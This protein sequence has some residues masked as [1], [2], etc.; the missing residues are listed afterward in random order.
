MSSTGRILNIARNALAAQESA[1]NTTGHNIA[2]VNTPGYSR[3]RTLFIPS[4]P[5]ATPWGMMGAGVDIATIEQLRD[6]FIDTEIRSELQDFGK[7]EYKERIFSQIE[8]IYNEPSD[9]GL[10]AVLRE[11]WD[12]WSQLANDPQSSSSRERV[13]QTGV[14][15]TNKFHNLDSRLKNL[16]SE[17]NEE[18]KHNIKDLNI[19]LRQVADLNKQIVQNENN[20]NMANDYRDRRSVLLEEISKMAN[21]NVTE[22]EHGSVTLT[23]DGN[24]LVERDTVNML[25]TGEKSIGY[26]ALSSP[27]MANTGRTVSILSGKL[28]GIMEMRD[29]VVGRQQEQLNEI[30]SALIHDVNAIHQAG[31]GRDGLSGRNFFDSNSINIGNIALDSSILEDAG[32]IAASADGTVGNGEVALQVGALESS[33]IMTNDTVTVEDY[34]AAMIGTIGVQA[35]ESGFMFE[36]QDLMVNQ[37]KNQQDSMAGVS[38]DEEMTN[39]IRYQHAYQA[40]ARLVRT[41]DEMMETLVNMV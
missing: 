11:F 39:L 40:A 10:S 26:I 32:K 9:V 36:N 41:V 6:K 30:A 16:Q 4:R 37:L 21:I 34:F 7:W 20:G 27:R 24:I 28:K 8:T 38:L 12:S 13:K 3:Q 18:L 2:N 5:E 19:N 15:L 23:L 14:A 33:K 35:Q 22:N 31:Y 17:M 25:E 29:D 1:I